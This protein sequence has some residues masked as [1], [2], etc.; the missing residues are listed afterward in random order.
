MRKLRT[1]ILAGSAVAVFAG[2]T[3]VVSGDRS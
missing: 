1:R 2:A 3:A